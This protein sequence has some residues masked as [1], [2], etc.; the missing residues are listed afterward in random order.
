MGTLT[1]PESE[2][3][4]KYVLIKVGEDVSLIAKKE[5]HSFHAQILGEFLLDN[6]LPFSN[7]TKGVPLPREEGYEVL[8]MGFIA[9]RINSG[10]KIASFVG[11][12]AYYKGLRIEEKYLDLIREN[13]PE[14]KV[15]ISKNSFL[16][17]LGT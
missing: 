2:K 5:E 13:N 15:E 1:I 12:S 4:L 17:I 14:W 10:H 9:V 3:R 6:N 16:D 8:A 7:D 11:E